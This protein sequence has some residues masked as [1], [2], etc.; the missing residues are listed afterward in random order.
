MGRFYCVVCPY[1][2]ACFPD[3]PRPCSPAARVAMLLYLPHVHPICLASPCFLTPAFLLPI[4]TPCAKSL[5]GEAKSRRL[6]GSNRPC[7]STRRP[8]VP[9]DAWA[10]HVCAGG[11]GTGL[12]RH[13]RGWV[14]GTNSRCG[15]ERGSERRRSEARENLLC[16]VPTKHGHV[17]QPAVDE[18]GEF[19]RFRCCSPV[20]FCRGVSMPRRYAPGRLESQTL[21]RRNACAVVDLSS[22]AA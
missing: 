1:F 15:C 2:L 7:C 18:W 10:T 16:P 9:Q 11:A 17:K 5:G 19:S 14:C 21:G 8:C 20:G 12:R 3:L 13:C 22:L 6:S 4:G